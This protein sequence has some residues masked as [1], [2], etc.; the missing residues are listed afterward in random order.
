MAEAGEHLYSG[1]LYKIG[2]ELWYQD[3][4]NQN[5]SRPLKTIKARGTGPSS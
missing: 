4:G 5:K 1:M 3:Y 2:S